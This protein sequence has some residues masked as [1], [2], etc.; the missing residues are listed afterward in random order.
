MKET[1]K[2]EVAEQIRSVADDIS[3]STSKIGDTNE[4][5]DERRKQAEIML[6]NLCKMYQL[7]YS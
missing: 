6:L 3:K 4:T 7:A 2:N 5:K 1:Q